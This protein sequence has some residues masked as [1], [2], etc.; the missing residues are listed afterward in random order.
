MPL[1]IEWSLV[2]NA[3]GPIES[4]ATAYTDALTIVTV[5]NT[6]YACSIP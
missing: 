2:D 3:N 4:V 5:S 6:S 1:T